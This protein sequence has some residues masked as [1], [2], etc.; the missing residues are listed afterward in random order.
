MTR[1]EKLDVWIIK[2]PSI[3]KFLNQ[4]AF[5]IVPPLVKPLCHAR[6][7]V[8]FLPDGY[9]MLMR[10]NYRS[11]QLSMAATVWVIWLCAC[12]RYWID[13]WLMFEGVTGFLFHT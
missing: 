9:D 10:P 7:L 11:K 8:L 13:R 12:V 1:A 5:S 2:I 4:F 6:L 3:T